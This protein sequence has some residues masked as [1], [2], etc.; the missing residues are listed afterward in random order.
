MILPISSNNSMDTGVSNN[1][2]NSNISNDELFGVEFLDGSYKVLNRN[3]MLA[4]SN[5]SVTTTRLT[6]VTVETLDGG[7]ENLC[8]GCKLNLANQQAHMDGNGCLKN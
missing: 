3:D 6:E 2:G 7:S 4:S 5:L 8:I 1:N